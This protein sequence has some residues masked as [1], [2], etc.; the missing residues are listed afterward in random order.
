MRHRCG[1]LEAG[2]RLQSCDL[3]LSA[4]VAKRALHGLPLRDDLQTNGAGSNMTLLAHHGCCFS[5]VARR[6][7]PGPPC[8]L[9]SS[10]PGFAPPWRDERRLA[11]CLPVSAFVTPQMTSCKLAQEAS[12]T[13]TFIKNVAMTGFLGCIRKPLLH[14]EYLY[15]IEGSSISRLQEQ[16]VDQRRR[17]SLGEPSDWVC[18]TRQWR[19]PGPT[20]W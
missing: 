19:S 6:V 5:P 15:K 7:P 3:L 2:R 13:M 8:R 1:A 16:R 11:P 18:L 14:K 10:P 20:G 4:L 17:G 12:C 9:A